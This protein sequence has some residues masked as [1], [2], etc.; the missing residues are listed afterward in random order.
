MPNPNAPTL[1]ERC[2]CGRIIDAAENDL[3]FLINNILH[4]RLGLDGA[5]CGPLKDHQLR[6]LRAA[7]DE[8]CRLLRL[9][10]KEPATEEDWVFG[11]PRLW[12][13]IF[14]FLAAH[15]PKPKEKENG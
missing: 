2:C 13:D 1:R 11:G 3:P 12:E 4:E 6:D 8:A 15:D 5:F 10:A 14:S 7:L 9:A